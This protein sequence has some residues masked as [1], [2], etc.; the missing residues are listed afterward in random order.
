MRLFSPNDFWEG[1]R[2]RDR[3]IPEDRVLCAETLVQVRHVMRP[4]NDND[5]HSLLVVVVV[6]RRAA[7]PASVVLV[8][9]TTLPVAVVLLLVATRRG[10]L[11]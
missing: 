10:V 6:A 11:S 1:R 7:P 2:L 3:W 4:Q 8:P 9:V 5:R